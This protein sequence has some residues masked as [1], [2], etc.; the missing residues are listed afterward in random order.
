MADQDPSAG[1]RPRRGPRVVATVLAATFV[2]WSLTS[3]ALLIYTH[4]SRDPVTRVLEIPEGANEL[5]AAG[6]NPLAIPVEWSLFADDLLVLD[7][8]DRVA[9]RL[10]GWI[11]D[12]HTSLEVTL[13]PTLASA[14]ICTLHPSGEITLDI[15]PR[16]F[17]WKQTV[18]P[19]LLLGP[20]LGLIVAG[21]RGVLRMLNEPDD[22]QP[23]AGERQ[24]PVPSDRT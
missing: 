13:Q 22:D 8:R 19:T 20:P 12:A 15:Q 2:I 24:S 9:H 6:E 23:P 11:V 16:D 10:G 3:I 1:P 21:S 14:L 4:G 7:N 18:F 17:D 5:I